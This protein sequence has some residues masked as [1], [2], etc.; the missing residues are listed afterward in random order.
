MIVITNPEDWFSKKIKNVDCSEITKSYIVNVLSN[1]H[2]NSYV[3]HNHSITLAWF[4][5]RCSGSF[6]KHQ[7]I[8]DWILWVK[9]VYPQSIKENQELIDS[10]GRLSY[11]ACY[12]IL[13]KKWKL[14]QELADNLTEITASINKELSR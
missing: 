9:S 10:I 13:S 5:A 8:G 4:D 14:Y 1:I 12:H 2:V 7:R 6:I 11:Y 3:S